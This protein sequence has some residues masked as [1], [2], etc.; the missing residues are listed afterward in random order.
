MALWVF[1][2]EPQLRAYFVV[3]IIIE[4]FN[5]DL[6]RQVVLSSSPVIV[7]HLLFDLFNILCAPIVHLQG[8]RIKCFSVTSNSC[9]FS[10]VIVLQVF[11]AYLSYLLYAPMVHLAGL[12]IKAATASRQSTKAY[13]QASPMQANSASTACS[14]ITLITNRRHGPQ[15]IWCIC[16]FVQVVFYT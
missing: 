14:F 16:I 6:E 5:L 8:L 11:A 1:A 12:R 7:L 9:I 15:I 3:H 4:D 13:T 10:F 2:I